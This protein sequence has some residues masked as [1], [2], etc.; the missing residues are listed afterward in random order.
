M[1][2]Q[3]A[4][5]FEAIDL[6]PLGEQLAGARSTSLIKSRQLQL[7]R[8]VLRAGERLREHHVRGEITLHCLEGRAQV[9]TPGHAIELSPGQLVLLPGGEPHAVHALQHTS[10][11]VTVS[12]H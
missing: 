4:R 3:H 6:H 8:V 11:L 5:A 12:L 7:L 1:S 2:L 10:L 9:S